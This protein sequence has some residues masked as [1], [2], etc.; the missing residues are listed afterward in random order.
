MGL[1]VGSGAVLVACACIFLGSAGAAA[2]S[3][4]V[5]AAKPLGVI[6]R[7]D[8]GARPAAALATPTAGAKSGS[9]PIGFAIDP[10]LQLTYHGGPVMHT[11]NVYAIFWV[12]SGYYYGSN[13]S[14]S[15]AYENSVEQWVHDVAHDDLTTSNAFGTISQYGDTTG[16]GAYN[17]HYGGAY[18]DTGP[19]V[20]PDCPLTDVHGVTDA[21]ACLTDQ[22]LYNE[23]HS[24]AVA[25]GW[26]GG[27]TSQFALILPN[28]VKSCYDTTDA[29]CSDNY[30]CAYHAW[31]PPG[32]SAP[33][34]YLDLPYEPVAAC[35]NN[36]VTDEPT[37]NGQVDVVLDDMSH[38]MR[39]STDDP[40]G[41]AWLDA[42]GNESDDKCID[43]YG[44]LLGSN[45]N[46]LINGDAYDTQLEWSN[47][48]RG[49]YQMG[50]PT[51][52]LD[53]TSATAGATV[54]IT[55]ANFFGV[56]PNPPIV[57]FNN[58]AATVTV[59]TPTH[60]TVTVPSGN[61]TGKVTVQAVGGTAT[62]TN[63]FGQKPSISLLSDSHDFTGTTL[64]VTGTGFFGVKSVKFNG[65]L[66]TFN[67]V[68]TN[69]TT[70]KAVV[71][72]AATSGN[73]T[74]TTT[75]GTSTDVAT[76]TVKPKIKSFTPLKAIGGSTVTITGTGLGGTTTVDFAGHTG[77]PVSGTPT[78]TSAKVVVPI[79]ATYGTL[80][81]NNG[82]PDS[83][84]SVA[85]FS[86]L[87]KI[88]LLSAVDGIPTDS[89]HVTGTNLLGA[90]AVKF[91]TVAAGA[92]SGVS[93]TG[94]DTVVPNA[95]LTS[96]AVSVTTPAGTA[97]STQIFTITA[98][99]G[100]TPAS[101]A[102][103]ATVTI[104][105]RG[106][107]DAQSVDF[108]G[109]SGVVPTSTTAT[110]VKVVVPSDATIGPLHVNMP[111]GDRPTTATFKPL[112]KI[113]GF[114][115]ASYQFGDTVTVTGSNFT[116]NGA[117]SATLGAIPLCPCSESATS[118]TF[119]VP[120]T[121]TGSVKA[122]NG[123]GTAISPTTL[124]IRPTIDSLTGSNDHGAA[125]AHITLTGKTFRGTTSVKVG[126][127]SASFTVA[128]D[129]NSLTFAVP[130]TAVSEP[131]TVTNAGGSTTSDSFAVT[132]VIKSFTPTS[133]PTGTT[134]TVAGT[135]FVGA[136]F[137]SFSGAGGDGTPTSVT[138]TSFKVV[139][140]SGTTTG[141]LAVET[142]VSGVLA[143]SAPSAS[144]FTA[145]FSVTTVDPTFAEYGDQVELSGV[146]FT[147]VTEVDFNG[148][149]GT[150]LNVV[151]D[152]DLTVDVPASGAVDGAITVKKGPTLSVTAPHPFA[153]LGV[154][155]L[156]K[157][158]G[159]PGTSVVITGIGFTSASHVKFHGTDAS[160]TVDSDT[161]ITASVPEG[162]STGAVSVQVPDV[163]TATGPSFTPES[164]AGV[165]INEVE[166]GSGGF[167]ELYNSTGATVDLTG[168]YLMFRPAGA[169]NGTTDSVIVHFPSSTPIDPG[170]WLAVDTDSLD[171]S[172]GGIALLYPDL[173]IVAKMGYGTA[174][175]A[176]VVGAAAPAPTT[177]DS[178]ARSPDGASSNDDGDD[179]H[180]TT[181]PTPG[182]ANDITP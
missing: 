140:P 149:P 119:T 111:D 94:F 117:L 153:L 19:Y 126:T 14:D 40:L 152:G 7:S 16:H 159:L 146:G 98:V 3:G 163:G 76:F 160:F 13:S 5:S 48:K 80:T 169:A 139:V 82:V 24:V 52:T 26:P 87:P 175:N 74:V 120:D 9:A 145:T 107:I 4:P 69:G 2:P 38:E 93:A 11:Q 162:A 73:V 171:T 66:G 168:A 25:E 32:S 150:S 122:V 6:K 58:F 67:T 91:G 77:V 132:P 161:Q 174:T 20:G 156:D 114:D 182:L 72:A 166:T 100:L 54:G 83:A 70:L 128:P 164:L 181:T 81:V 79:D 44:S 109:H 39:E 10:T 90:S 131:I 172:G 61:T 22:D 43:S 101:A 105:G 68:A 99:T 65:V 158:A 84:T 123:D 137:V 144:P 115:H 55:G 178:I 180:V 51:A 78:A 49:C 118:F 8:S 106:L 1:K 127:V 45:Y 104:T 125:G 23:V 34:I 113:T 134:L 60:L 59:A 12:P 35:H 64:T 154:D 173:T 18:V 37:P 108:T 29:N 121:V 53:A 103:G 142:D 102:S 86:P 97:T 89:V 148:F 62:A 92:P 151:N 179:F 110:S 41:N 36:F 28:T 165:S 15:T 138:A 46:Q 141:S 33:Y 133:G 56:N 176:W 85:S 95:F 136:D 31:Y 155:S 57:K 130:T 147:G 30:F 47:A 135:G 116:A 124:K 143:T 50:A 17:V 42:S 21:S 88:T 96:G 112:P 27:L 71:P 129:G 167:V 157:A 75:G 63:T 177:G 170:G